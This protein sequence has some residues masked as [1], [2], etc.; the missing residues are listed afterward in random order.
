MVRELELAGVHTLRGRFEEVEPITCEA[1]VAQAVATPEAL[2]AQLEPWSKP[3]GL[4]V[5]PGGE[6]PREA[7]PH[8]GLRVRSLEYR[9]P[10][11]GPARTVWIAERA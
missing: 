11:G 9:V 1:V 7:S 6:T 10:L 2:V 4:L 5:V 3:G 8:P